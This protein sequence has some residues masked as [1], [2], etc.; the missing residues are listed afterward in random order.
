VTVLPSQL[1][2]SAIRTMTRIFST[3]SF[4]KK[5]LAPSI[6]LT[7]FVRDSPTLACR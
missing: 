4:G 6:S 3:N 5:A 7:V 2:G 1:T